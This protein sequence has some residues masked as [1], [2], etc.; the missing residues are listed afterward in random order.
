MTDNIVSVSSPLMLG[1]DHLGRDK[2]NGAFESAQNAQIQIH[3]AHAQ[4]L[5]RAFALHWYII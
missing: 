4:S 1:A 5:I 2:R 3:I